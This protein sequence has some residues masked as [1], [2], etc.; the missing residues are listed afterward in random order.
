MRIIWAAVVSAVFVVACGG[1][2]E[3]EAKDPSQYDPEHVS[4]EQNKNE[5]DPFY[6][7]DETGHKSDKVDLSDDSEGGDKNKKE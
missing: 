1:G 2:S 6:K 5:V 7:G 3:K 4:D